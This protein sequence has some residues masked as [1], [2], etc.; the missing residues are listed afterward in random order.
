MRIIA[1][2]LSLAILCAVH[3]VAGSTPQDAV[4][5]ELGQAITGE[6]P[7]AY[8]KIALD[9]PDSY[10]VKMISVPTEMLTWIRVFDDNDF[11]ADTRT[12]VPGELTSLTFDITE[13]GIYYVGVLE[14]EGK[15]CGPYTFGVVPHSDSRVLMWR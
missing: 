2:V 3:P 4:E 10:T 6:T 12:S 8:Y 15:G 11:F 13:P 14:L 7:G 5:I 1:F 9:D